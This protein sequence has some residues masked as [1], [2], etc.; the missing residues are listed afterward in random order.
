MELDTV[1]GVWLGWETTEKRRQRELQELQK[2]HSCHGLVSTV[3]T[4]GGP[5]NLGHSSRQRALSR[6][7]MA[8]TAARKLFV[9]AIDM[10][11]SPEPRD[12]WPPRVS[13]CCVLA[14]QI[15]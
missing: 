9:A 8:P 10:L 2:E 4:F 5:G 1:V 3:L 13:W 12:L 7:R 11:L 14:L 6:S 15:V